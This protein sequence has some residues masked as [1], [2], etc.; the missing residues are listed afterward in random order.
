MLAVQKAM[1]LSLE[2]RPKEALAGLGLLWALICAS[3]GPRAQLD[4]IHPL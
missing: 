4:L 2:K 3:R 1:M